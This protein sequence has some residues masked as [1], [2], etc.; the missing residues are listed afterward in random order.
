MCSSVGGLGNVRG[1]APLH[2]I[3]IKK[4]GIVAPPI[5]WWDGTGG[6]REGG[7]RGYVKHFTLL[8]L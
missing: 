4:V 3:L 7:W 8:E 5:S 6:A 2:G 1:M